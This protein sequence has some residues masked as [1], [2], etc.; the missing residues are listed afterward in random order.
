MHR[1]LSII[2][3][4]ISTLLLLSTA[5]AGVDV[6]GPLDTVQGVPNDGLNA[7]GDDNGWP[8]N[9]LPPFA[10]D[11]QILTKFLHFKGDTEP[12]GLR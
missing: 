12:T 2:V 7:G 6:T 10:F 11:N 3:V 8:P 9:E 1:K 4:I 5:Q